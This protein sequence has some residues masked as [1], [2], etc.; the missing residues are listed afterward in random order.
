MLEQKH[1]PPMRL[2]NRNL[3][4]INAKQL[5]EFPARQHT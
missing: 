1:W 4:V 5:I 2:L 3:Q